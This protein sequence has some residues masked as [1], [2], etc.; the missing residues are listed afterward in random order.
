MFPHNNRVAKLKKPYNVRF[1]AIIQI[2]YQRE[3]VFFF[4]QHECYYFD[5][6]RSW[7]DY[8]IGKY[9]VQTLD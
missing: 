1:H 4:Q 5:E 8:Q 6:S 3:R 2:I 9:H 7:G